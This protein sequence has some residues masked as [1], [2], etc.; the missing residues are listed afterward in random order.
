MFAFD[1]TLLQGKS[2]KK[3]A[4]RLSGLH[5]DVAGRLPERQRTPPSA[6]SGVSFVAGQ[7]DG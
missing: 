6:R 7:A 5:V 1:L 3:L 4:E 2:V